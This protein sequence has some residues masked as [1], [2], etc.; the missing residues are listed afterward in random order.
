[1]AHYVTLIAFEGQLIIPALS[2]PFGQGWDLLGTAAYQ[3]NYTWL[4]PTAVWY[5]Q[6]A[7]VVGG[8]VAGVTLA[9]DRALAVFPGARA[10]RS[11][12]AMLALMVGLTALAL[13]VLA[14][15]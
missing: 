4:S 10:V 7:A 2:D 3:V 12:Y 13:T 1:L 8:H 14:T 5:L 9:H 11:Q 6:L 15:G